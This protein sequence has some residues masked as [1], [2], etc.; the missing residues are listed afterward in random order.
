MPI[1]QVP[2]KALM[3][4]PRFRSPERTETAI[5]FAI[6]TRLSRAIAGFLQSL[7]AA[8]HESRLEKARREIDS[9]RHLIPTAKETTGPRGALLCRGA[10]QSMR[11]PVRRPTEARREPSH[12][13]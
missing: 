8:L 6:A 2:L 11:G 3:E 12:A 7:L 4:M 9:L 1:D 5:A 10:D 13:A